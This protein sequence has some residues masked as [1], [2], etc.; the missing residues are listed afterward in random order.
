MSESEH[1][2]D[3]EFDYYSYELH[4]KVINNKLVKIPLLN[5]C[6]SPKRF[7]IDFFLLHMITVKHKT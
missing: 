5:D 6:E 7:E 1:L 3:N 2:E 4:D